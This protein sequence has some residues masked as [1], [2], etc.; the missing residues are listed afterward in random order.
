VSHYILK[1]KSI[2]VTKLQKLPGSNPASHKFQTIFRTPTGCL[3]MDFLFPE[4]SV[5]GLFNIFRSDF[6]WACTDLP[7]HL[8]SGHQLFRFTLL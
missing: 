1:I 6:G 4:C 2:S 3:H 8:C 7:S 5:N